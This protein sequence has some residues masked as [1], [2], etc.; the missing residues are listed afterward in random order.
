MFTLYIYN[1]Q[2]GF[3]IETL[4][5]MV[6][7]Y[8]IPYQ[9]EPATLGHAFFSA[10]LGEVLSL[11][12]FSTT[13]F[14]ETLFIIIVFLFYLV[15]AMPLFDDYRNVKRSSS[16]ILLFIILILLVFPAFIIEPLLYSRGYFGLVTSI[17]LLLCAFRFLEKRSI[18]NVV[19]LTTIFVSSSISY[20]LPPLIMT[21]S[22]VFL[23]VA[24]KI[25][26]FTPFFGEIRY[27]R[28][29]LIVA[30][31]LS[32]I[33]IVIQVYLGYSSWNVLHE[34]I[35]KWLS[36]EF[37]TSFEYAIAL[38]Y[39]GEASV[40][41]NLR[42]GVIL[43][44][45]FTSA[46]LFL[47]LTLKIYGEKRASQT[48]LFSAILLLMYGVLGVIYAIGFHEPGLRFY[49]NLLAALPF[50]YSVIATQGFE[51]FAKKKVPLKALLMIPLFL[52]VFSLA[53]SPV[54]KWGW[55]FV[56]YPTK[57]DL[58]LTDFITSF[59]GVEVSKT[60]AP[61]SHELLWFAFESSRISDSTNS[62]IP[63]ILYAGD[64]TFTLDKSLTADLTVTY[65][66]IFIYSRW[67]GI[68][69]DMLGELQNAVLQCSKLYD[70]GEFYMTLKAGYRLGA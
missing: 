46:F 13:R 29:L 70:A 62:F 18:E 64:V 48:E 3:A 41:L 39:V 33:W 37:F 20:P 27:N 15:L 45:W 8:V 59:S 50:S 42:L 63:A 32:A 11:D 57:H 60:Y 65:Y 69:Q 44:G 10:I 23:A 19:V 51:K 22:F 30:I 12:L 38:K 26:I 21:V 1:D 31:A 53:L 17:P 35:S 52:M 25:K 56:A 5:G 34:I 24:S 54:V 40:Y 61:G 4:S 47:L 67:L 68:Y 14:V 9:G 66:R 49:R 16:S 28:K 36:F 2:L 6:R 55:V 43:F 7:G 58:A